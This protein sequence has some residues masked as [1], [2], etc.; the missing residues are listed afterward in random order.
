M[1]RKFNELPPDDRALFNRI[2]E[3]A[4][5]ATVNSKQ[6]FKYSELT[7]VGLKFEPGIALAVTKAA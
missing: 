7:S 5:K 6:V 4:Y 3:L 1:K 2:C